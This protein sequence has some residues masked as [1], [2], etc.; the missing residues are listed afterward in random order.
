LLTE[1]TLEKLK[2]MRLDGLAAAWLEQ[3]QQAATSELAFDERLG[4]LV[5]AEWLHR[6]N[7]K[8]KRALSEAKLRLAQACVED[9]DYSA[10]REI[11]KA[12]VRQLASCRWISEHQALL[13]TGMTGTGKSY[14]ACALAHQACRK[15]FRAVYRRAS[16]LFDELKLARADGTYPRVLARLARIDVLVIDDFAVAPV[17]DAQRAD[18]LE[19]LEDR[20]GVRSTIVTSQLP[21]AQWHDYLADPTL[22]DAICDR[23]LNNA[24]RLVLKGPSKRKEDKKES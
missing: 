21:P 16:R 19:V 24:H 17:T 12:V 9:I 3:Q 23:L 2:K 7:K 1:P 14:L 11:D 18:L 13:I 22:A 6:E 8:M 5:D 15:G 20:Y 4:L 10:R